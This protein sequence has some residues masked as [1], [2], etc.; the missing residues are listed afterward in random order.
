MKVLHIIAIS[1]LVA[2]LL[3][4]V[5]A[6]ALGDFDMHL[7]DINK[8]IEGSETLSGDFTHIKTDT[9][10]GDIR[11][12]P[13]KDDTCRV[14]YRCREKM[15]YRIAIEGDTLVIETED[16]RK[17]YDHITFFSFRNCQVTVYLPESH[18]TSLSVDTTT[19]DVEVP[20]DFTFD[21]VTIEGTTS[22]IHYA[23]PTSGDVSITVTTGDV[24]VS[25][26]TL[27]QLTVKASTGDIFLD[28]VNSSTIS[29]KNTTGEMQIDKCVAGSLS[30]HGGTTDVE[31]EDTRA[32]NEMNISVS[33]GDVEFERCDAGSMTI[34]TTTG[35]VEG[36]LLS[37]K[38]FLCKTNTGE[39]HVPGTTTGGI[40]KITCTTGDIEITIN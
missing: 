39:I 31:M 2:G 21:T 36:S 5:I 9:V 22:D 15:S 3:L 18:Y 17:W 29:L 25:R 24:K 1:C 35:D 14:E 32:I 28:H 4:G 34:N 38:I 26:C 10:E 12:L 27:H 11:F 19:G 20:K 13:S 23:A 33:T 8:Y 37:P 7:F 30:I 40:C 6:L 16:H